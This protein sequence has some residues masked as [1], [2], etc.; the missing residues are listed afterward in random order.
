MNRNA[1]K[2]GRDDIS[3][4]PIPKAAKKYARLTSKDLS[5]N[6]GKKKVDGYVDMVA[7]ITGQESEKHDFK[8]MDKSETTGGKNLAD[9]II[10][11]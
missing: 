11:K 6:W 8:D 3:S 1:L 2:E 10:G 4:L 7:A 9:K 5:G